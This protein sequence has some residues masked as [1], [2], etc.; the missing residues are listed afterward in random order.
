MGSTG[1]SLERRPPLVGRAE[2]LAEQLGFARSCEPEVG[3]LLHV[4]A[5][6]R[7]RARVGEIGTGTGVGAAWIVSALPP[8]VPFV[9]VELDPARAAAAAS[10]FAA[11]AQVRVLEGDWHELMPR[12]APFDLLFYDGGGKQR[13][14][15]DGEDVVGLLAP[16]GLVVMDD[17]TPGRP[18]AGDPVREFWLG[19]PDLS[20]VELTLSPSMAAIVAVRVR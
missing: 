1:E 15:L 19:H 6:Q 10:L 14:E 2:E 8:G 3:R 9:T 4:L 20:A 16:R 7:G 13:P 11:D 5:A 18:R 17:L 12:E